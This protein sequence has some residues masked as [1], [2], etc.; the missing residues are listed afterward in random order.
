M[1]AL[2]IVGI[3]GCV[4]AALFLLILKIGKMADQTMDQ[5]MDKHELKWREKT[6]PD[7]TKYLL[8]EEHEPKIERTVK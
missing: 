2:T 8:P 1:N 4:I 7:G 3:V 6:A 5:I